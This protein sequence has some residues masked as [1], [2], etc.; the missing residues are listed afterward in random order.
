METPVFRYNLKSLQRLLLKV[1]LKTS[2]FG[3]LTKNG[4]SKTYNAG[5]CPMI[6][7]FSSGALKFI[8]SLFV[9]DKSKLLVSWT[10]CTM[11]MTKSGNCGRWS[12]M[13]EM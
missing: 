1:I 13:S 4:R 11:A 12:F 5:I 10:C 9:K 2:N 8:G 3:H 7:F 6:E